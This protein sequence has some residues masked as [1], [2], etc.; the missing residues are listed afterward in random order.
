M[1]FLHM[2]IGFLIYSKKIDLNLNKLYG[3]V[4]CNW[5][6]KEFIFIGFFCFSLIKYSFRL[7]NIIY[8]VGK[9]MKKYEGISSLLLNLQYEYI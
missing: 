7:V 4:N 3:D 2:K 5:A 9:C 6:S 8:I 1:F